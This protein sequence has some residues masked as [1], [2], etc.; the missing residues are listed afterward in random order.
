MTGKVA[1][2]AAAFLFL[3]G[4]F[5]TALC[6]VEDTDSFTHLAVGRAIWEARGIPAVEPF[7]ASLSGEP[8][9]YPS[10]LFAVS[11][12]TAF[13]AAGYPGVV[14]LMAASATALFGVLYLVARGRGAPPA[15]ALPVLALAVPWMR[16]RFVERPDLWSCLFLAFTVLLLEDW[17]RNGGRRVFWLVPATLAWANVHVNVVLAAIPWAAYLGDAALGELL[18]RRRG[19]AGAG[20]SPEGGR[21]G[22]RSGRDLAVLA[23]AGA[24]A[25]LASLVTPWGAGQYLA[26]AGFLE[27]AYYR[28]EIHEL[29]APTWNGFRPAIVLPWIVAASFLL[30]PRKARLVDL[31]LVVPALA[32]SLTAVRFFVYGLVVAAPIVAANVATALEALAD[33]AG[34]R[35]RRWAVAAAWGWLAAWPALAAA[36]LYGPPDPEKSFGLGLSEHFV[37]EKAARFLD[38]EGVRGV[39]FNLFQLGGYVAWRD[40]PRR[41]PV[42][43]GRGTKAELLESLSTAFASSTVLERLRGRFGFETIL[44]G[45]PDIE[46]GTEGV[47]SGVDRAL[48]SRKGWSLVFWDDVALVYLRTAGPYAATV[49]AQAY[50]RVLP[51][52]PVDDLLASLRDPDGARELVEELERNVRETGSAR[53]RILLGIALNELG[54]PAESLAV[55]AE[56]G[57]GDFD[58]FRFQR[59]TTL[60]NAQLRLG[61]KEEALASF[62]SALS[63]RRTA[64]LHASVARIEAERGDLRA[65]VRQLEKAIELNPGLDSAWASLVELLRRSGRAAEAA[66][67]EARFLAEA[68]KRLGEEAFREGLKAYTSRRLDEGRALFEKSV[69]A[70]PAN[71]AAWSNLGFL[72]YDAGNLEASWRAQSR[73]LQVDPAFANAHYGLAQLSR[74]LGNAAQE[75]RHWEEYLRLQPSG[76]YSRRA[77]ER[78]SELGAAAASKAADGR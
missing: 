8:F 13:R 44:V 41:V 45:Y 42:V 25:A 64:G 9:L 37:S 7:A 65:A 54:R 72:E 69:A 27:K 48:S 35:G 10:W 21:N 53:G 40:F 24:L 1:R 52:N 23:G 18:R 76:Y 70:N 3:A 63:V 15:V 4:V 71:P 47:M 68:P 46:P 77:A 43:D 5:V 50:R 75:R 67:V 19:E 28:Q 38:R 29:R 30:R 73:A 22:G 55:L 33:R 31:L 6:R 11:F 57:R 66:R 74:R 16:F 32:L 20:G 61:R 58:G 56:R 39:V 12:F 59:F 34:A 14:L 49:D 17:R 36:R 2:R 26:T 60:G 51:A 62:E 78:L